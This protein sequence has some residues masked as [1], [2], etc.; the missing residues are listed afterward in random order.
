MSSYE[1]LNLKLNPFKD[2]TPS[3]DSST[4]WAGMTDLKLK[5]DKSYQDC[6]KNKS[7]QIILNW[8]P[9]GGGKTFSAN[10]FINEYKEITQIYIR[11]P[12]DGNSSTNEFFKSIIDQISFSK[13]R[14]QIRSIIEKNGEEN[15]FQFLA[16]KTG[17]E[18]AKAIILIA[19]DDNEIRDIMHRYLYVGVTKTELKKLGLARDLKSDTE[20]IKFLTG[21]LWCFIGDGKLFDGRVVIWIDEMEDIIYYSP[22]NYKAF[23]QVLRDLFDSISQ[24]LLVFMNFTLAE[25]VETTIEL[26]LG[27]AVWSRITKRIRYKELTLGDAFSYCE[28][29]I[30]YAQI[31]NSTLQPFTETSVKRTLELIPIGILTPREINRFFGS[32]INYASERGVNK[33]DE[34]IVIDW[35]KE[36][37]DENS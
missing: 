25:G 20:S 7:K 36:F 12:K 3:A 26:V 27:G 2:L 11:S 22:K 13:I 1:T 18:F 6:L 23:S 10:Y 5:I 34:K 16:P 33:I 17:Q 35:S 37:A 9:Y 28:D 29:L 4:V 8:G 19:S 21:V 30:K 15:L 14:E 31:K 24:S 32:I